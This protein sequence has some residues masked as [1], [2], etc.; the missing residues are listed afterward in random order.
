MIRRL[1]AIVVAAAALAA[2]AVASEV[3]IF[4][5]QSQEA[6]LEGRFDGVSVDSL[7]TLRLTAAATR[8]T[9]LEEPFVLA[10]ATHPDGWVLGTGNA[11]RVLL[12]RKDGVV[13]ELMA[14]AEP[15]VFAVWAD[16][17]GVV[18]AGT[19]PS[20]KV[21]RIADGEAEVF[22]DPGQ[23]YIWQIVGRDD[24]SLV[25]ATGTEGRLYTVDGDGDGELLWDSDDTH[26]RAVTVLEDG[27]LLVGTAGEGLIV[28]IEA[29]GRIRTLYDA[30]QPE[31]VAFAEG[32][33]G[34][35]YAA[36]VASEASQLPAPRAR[37][38]EESEG[39]GTVV[40]VVEEPQDEILGS[41]PRG[42][43]GPRSEILRIASSGTVE[44][45]ARLEDE[46][47]YSLAFLGGRLWIGTGLEGK[48]FTLSGDD[49]VLENDVEE[50]Q[51]MS[52]LAD[53][54]H[55]AFA[56]TNAAAF[57]R[58]GVDRARKGTYTSPVLDAG[59]IAR[60]GTFRWMGQTGRKG[61]LRFSF[62]SGI[63]AEP[64]Q[65][66]SE[67]SEPA[68]GDELGLLAIPPAR[69]IQWRLEMSGSETAGPSLVGAEL[70]YR[71][72]NLAPRIS[73]LEVLDPGKVIVSINFN[74]SKQVFEPAHPTRDGIFTTLK[75]ATTRDVART[76]EL[77]KHG[78]RTLRWKAEDPNED[79]LTYRLEFRLV[80]REAWLSVV[81]D[82]EET[83][84][85]FDSTALPDG[86]YRFRLVASDRANGGG[87][88]AERVSEPVVV[89]HSP[90]KIA[91]TE[92][93]GGVLSVRVED[94]LSPLREAQYSID[95]G[96]WERAVVADGLLDGRSETL[97]IPRPADGALLM[98]QVADAAF[99]GVTF[100]LS[101]KK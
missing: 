18:F 14:A 36:V 91:S 80:E 87:L 81:A 53:N 101:S 100:D 60:F 37:E 96:D 12:V 38:G 71:Q 74:P 30:D 61:R 70:S 41:R 78:F 3:R 94:E 62:R 84:Y 83:Y 44:G 73:S 82:R 54:G 47:V 89:D 97:E 92:R 76:K 10:A 16:D 79:E 8:L 26:I 31:V 22:F 48:L 25:V 72:D 50:R 9:A 33:D 32:S 5:L 43:Q 46:T 19:S 57:Y 64:D 6:F 90:P 69:F 24:G 95:G 85:S 15:E 98:V 21:Y 67:W 51:I 29:D 11:G 2:A 40:V 56:T 4:R 39:E 86:I 63:S 59:Q 93:R 68:S 23:T 99:N 42:F 49:L 52:L 88:E 77:W 20:G 66:W 34:T 45:V 35:A 28:R 13:E 65:T 55:P 75:A 7:G 1:T 27:G 17:D 58:L